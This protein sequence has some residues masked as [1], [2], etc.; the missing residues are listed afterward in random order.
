MCRWQCHA[1]AQLN[2]FTMSLQDQGLHVHLLCDIA[3]C[4]PS[5]VTAPD[6][7]GDWTAFL[8]LHSLLASLGTWTW[9]CTHCTWYLSNTSPL[10]AFLGMDL[11]PVMSICCL[12][13]MLRVPFYRARDVQAVQQTWDS[14]SGR[15]NDHLAIFCAHGTY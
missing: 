10:A 6:T 15:I 1:W 11:D 2:P 3:N 9:H 13:T 4:A 7:V 5:F 14:S 12:K 8:E